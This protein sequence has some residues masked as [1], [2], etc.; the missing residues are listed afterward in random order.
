MN[1]KSAK[2]TIVLK[3]SSPNRFLDLDSK[4]DLSKV[5]EVLNKLMA[6]DGDDQ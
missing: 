4:S 3:K 5:M 1:K 6:G 2:S